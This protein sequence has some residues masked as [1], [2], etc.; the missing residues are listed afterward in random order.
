[1]KNAKSHGLGCLNAQT[2]A[3]CVRSLTDISG[4]TIEGLTLTGVDGGYGFCTGVQA[5]RLQGNG[6]TVRDCDIRDNAAP[7]TPA[8]ARSE[9]SPSR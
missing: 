4:T 6:N 1:M 5:L 9:K 7:R 8:G 2:R 3:Y